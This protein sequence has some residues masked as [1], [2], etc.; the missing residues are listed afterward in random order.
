MHPRPPKKQRDIIALHK[1]PVEYK[2]L[3]VLIKRR[4]TSEKKL[5][6]VISKKCGIAV[7]R[8]RIRRIIREWFRIYWDKLPAH[9]SWLI[10]VLPKSQEL[11]AKKISISIREELEEFYKQ[12]SLPDSAN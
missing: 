1:A 5:V 2:G 4:K 10:K 12:L 3:F 11:S 6:I 7:R 8:N 9:E